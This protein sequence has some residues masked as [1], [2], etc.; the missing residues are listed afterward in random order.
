MC[1]THIMH[2]ICNLMSDEPGIKGWGCGWFFF[3][4]RAAI[5]GL[6]RAARGH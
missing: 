3:L 4:Y 5:L 6:S 1:H 2:V